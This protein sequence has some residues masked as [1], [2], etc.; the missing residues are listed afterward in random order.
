MV[1]SHRC[2]ECGAEVGPN[3]PDGAC[4]ACAFKGALLPVG[5]TEAGG[6]TSEPRVHYFGDYALLGEVGKGGMGVV[7]R[8]RQVSLN[9]IV[10]LKV[11]R[12]GRLASDA[13]VLRFKQEAE[14]AANLKHPNIVTIYEIGKYDGQHYYSMEFVKG[15]NFEQLVREQPMPAPQAAQY[16]KTIAEA[17]H[18][19]HEKETIHRDL[20]PTNILIDEF[21][22]PR[23]TDFG[24]ARRTQLDQR[25]TV[26]GQILGTPAFMAPEQAAGAST[27]IG[28]KTDVYGVGAVLYFLLTQRAPF[29]AE[30]LPALLALVGGPEPPVSPRALNPGVPR[31]LETI[32]LKCLDKDPARRYRSAKDLSEELGRFCRGEPILARPPTMVGRAWR[33]CARNRA[34][35]SS[36]AAAALVLVA[37]TAVSAWEAVRAKAEAAKSQ[38]IARFLQDMLKGV[39]PSVALGR[40]TTMLRE[41]LD[42]TA[43]RVGKE[44]KNQPAARADLQTIIGNVYSELGLYGKAEAMHREV[45]ATVTKLYGPEHEE[46]ATALCNLGSALQS[47]SKLL[48][49]ERLD[50]QALAMRRKL[51]GNEHRDVA[52][53]LENLAEVLG[54]EGKLAEAETMLREVV[55]IQ[56]RV[57]GNEHPDVAT[58]I[59]NVA[60]T[61]RMEGKFE[62]AEAMEREA[63]AMRKKLLGNEH[64]DVATSLN[65]VA[66]VLEEEGKLNEAESLYRQ[67]LTLRRKVLGNEHPGVAESLNNLAILF[68]DQG[69][70]PEAEA[71]HREALEI[72]RKVLGARH[73]DVANSLNNLALVLRDE[74]KLADAENLEREALALW[75]TI[76]G[77]EHFQVATALNSLAAILSDQGNLT[78][79]EAMQRQ[80]LAMQKKLL[81]AQHPAVAT[82]LNN[83]AAIVRDEG[84]FAEAEELQRE[85]LAMQKQLLGPEHIIV[86]TC[87]NNLGGVLQQQA[88]LAD[89][90]AAYRDALAMQ[91]KLLGS[92]H[93]DVAR[94]LH[95]LG[96][97][98]REQG[99]LA[100]AEQTLREA[101]AMRR[102]TLGD[103]HPDVA[104][105][106]ERLAEV[107]RAAG[108]PEEAE[109]LLREC[110]SI[111]E[112]ALPNDWSTF[113]ARCA[114]G[115]TLMARKKYVE[116]EPLLVSG[117]E[118][119][120]Q[121]EAKIPASNRRRLKEAINAL[122]RLYEETGQQDK[123]AQWKQTLA[124][125]EKADATATSRSAQPPK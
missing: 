26:T 85:S 91:R 3:A 22:Q 110:L 21:N 39:G 65:G 84:R 2:P 92:D 58:S 83:L 80:A 13:D 40:D 19:A 25:L 123:T 90:E 15:Q 66:A 53:S 69:K 107:V 100:E 36:L 10:A 103:K 54:L 4:P 43:E 111:R 89:A 105:S 41:I 109:T 14:S 74:V 112:T 113:S 33:W 29:T 93:P 31:D 37:G 78:E 97:V 50:R 42:K 52:I 117:Y 86:A 34:V 18:F 67:A 115:G 101:L 118:G 121:R 27:T 63:L 108:R 79:A 38:Q 62:Q 56:K 70:L 87:L 1:E 72:Y 125:L 73:P 76:Y 20:K 49:A 60:Q 30:S 32:C 68:Q 35:A 48:D 102:K 24:L 57:L 55:A 124:E 11:I 82:S 77:P 59:Q 95:N 6:A 9:R 8:A 7:Y 96:D 75:K 61:L 114:L 28:P 51:L 5:G 120:Q 116:A 99:K 119:L 94:S 71:T 106:L 23:I 122:I 47:Q 98:L 17:I 16:L 44:L 104:V 12:V 64:P 46:V 45:L 81:G 88:K